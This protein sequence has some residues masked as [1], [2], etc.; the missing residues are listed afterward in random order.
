MAMKRRDFLY[1]AGAASVAAGLGSRTA[2]AFVPS[3][4]WEKHDFGPGPAVR[5][6][7]YQGPFPQYLPEEIVPGSSVV[8]TTTPSTDIVPNYGMG[9]TVYLSGDYWPPRTQGASLEKYCEDLIGLPFAQKVYVRLNWRDIQTRP[10]KLDFPEG[11]KVAFDVARRHGKRIGFRVMLENPD[12]PEP[13]M[14]E[15]LMASVPYVALKGH[16]ERKSPEPRRKALNQ[17]PRYDHPAYQAA[18]KELN[19]LL[20]AE[21]NGNSQ[22]EYMDTFMYGFWGEGH[23]WPYEGHP[24]PDNVLAERTWVQM[25][26]TQLETWTKTPLVTNTQPDFSRVGNSE[27]LDRTVRSH[28]WI[29]TD[30]IFIENE[31]IEPLSNRPPWA[32]AI[33]ESGMPGDPSRLLSENGLDHTENILQHVLDVGANYWSLWNFHNI[34]ASSLRAVHEK[35]PD[36]FDRAARRIGYR[37]RPSWIW[38]YQKEEH[39]G[40]VIGL[41]NDGVACVPGAL[42]LTVFSE[43]GKVNVSGCV[44]SGYP[45]TRGVRQAMLPLPQGTDWK[46]LRLKAELEV[47]G[48]RHP[49]TWAC[50]QAL[51]RDGS[52]TL[53]PTKGVS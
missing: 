25:F 9:L 13:G 46:G 44:D 51:N 18:F 17:M 31:Q 6:R 27:L 2:Q 35:R 37:I 22:V 26:E 10:G 5:D 34:S 45:M 20:A 24:F 19:G 39:P 14:P 41:V 23:T 47:K 29:R 49:I 53:A 52:L 4:N 38:S 11:W 7:L 36:L 33:C 42:R 30:T 21:L 15:F 48:Q 28:N 43:D 50:R 12:H 16:W 40:L 8:M 3:H 1:T 32:A